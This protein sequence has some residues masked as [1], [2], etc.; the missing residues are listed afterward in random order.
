MTIEN[1][2]LGGGPRD[3]GASAPDAQGQPAGGNST[4]RGAAGTAGSAAAV[5]WVAGRDACP[6]RLPIFEG[7]L[8]LLMHLIR[9]NEL[10]ITDLPIA[11]IADQYLEY[12]ELMRELHLDV[13]AEYLVMAASLAWIKSRLL[14]PADPDAS[15]E[16]EEDPRAALVA[17]LLEY[18]RFREAAARLDTLPRLGRD[19]FAAPGGLPD[20]LPDSE[21][22]LEVGLLPLIAAFRSVIRR[23]A[24]AQ[25]VH[26]VFSEPVGV[27]EQMVAIVDALEAQPQLELFDFLNDRWG[28]RP[29][30]SAIVAT[31]LALLELAR[32]SVLRVFQSVDESG[33]PRGPIYLRRAGD[34]S[35]SER[36]ATLT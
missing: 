2:I 5:T 15:E 32:L 10:E 36:L 17:R 27:R 21:R 6:I 31:F 18:Q 9:E 23:G 20:P 4:S 1:S 29:R 30:R 24:A 16:G 22:E 33:A 12:L 7:P 25:G 19:Q 3:R 35:A 28:A 13:A 11:A 14:L 8:D 26:E 34:A